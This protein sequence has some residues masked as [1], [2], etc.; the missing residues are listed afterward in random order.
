MSKFPGQKRGA[1]G[2]TV[3]ISSL[4][5]WAGAA[6]A[7]TTEPAP[8]PQAEQP[9]PADA[10]SAAPSPASSG[11]TKPGDAL[12]EVEVIQKEPPK[13]KEPEEAEVPVKKKPQPVAAKNPDVQQP[14]VK[15]AKAPAVQEAEPTL[16]APAP[17]AQVSEPSIAATLPG[18]P[19]SSTPV[20]MSPLAGSEIPLD[21][22]P[23]GVSIVSAS[24]IA[25]DGSGQLQNALAQYVPGI[26]LSDTA[27]SGFRTDVSYRGFDS[28]PVGGRSQGLAIYQN[29]VRVN[30]SF[31]DTMNWDAIPANAINDITVV[32]NNP[33]FGLNAI[34]G[35]I[36]LT[37]KDG[38]NYQGAEIDVMGGSFGRRQIAIQAGAKSG[39]FG[40]YAAGEALQEDGF[41][42]FSEAKVRRMY[43][44]LGVKSDLAE[45]HFSFTGARSEA[46]VVTAAPVELL[47]IDYGRTFTSPQITE[48]EVL[49]PT[50]S[51]SLKATETL[52]LSANAYYRS[53]KQ[54]VIDGNLSAAVPCT[55]DATILCIT[56]DAEEVVR[57][58]QGNAA[59]S[60]IGTTLGAIDRVNQEA[61]SHGVTL[62]AVEKS[63]LFGLGNQFLIG[64]SYDHGKVAYDTSSELGSIGDRF[65]VTGAGFIV[66]E[67]DDLLPR[68]LTSENDYYGLYFSNALD[69]TD[70]FTLTV[71]GRYNNATIKLT[72]LTGNFP[73]LNVTSRFERFNPMI[74]GTYKVMPGLSVYGGYSE[75]NR[76]PTAAELSCANPLNP[77]LI[78]SFLTDDPPLLQV[79]SHTAEVGLRGEQLSNGGQKLSWS[80]GYFHTLNQDDIINV[81]AT[82]TGRGYFLNAGDTL[83]QGIELAAAYHTERWSVYGSYAFIDATYQTNLV[84]PAP[85]TPG[86]PDCPGTVPADEAPCNFVSAGDHLPGIPQHRFKAGFNYW[87]T[88]QWKIGSDVITAS[89]QVFFGD[90]ANNNERLAGYTRVDLNTSYD[91]SENFQ[92]YG[93][94]KNLFDRR[95]GLYGTFFDT[96]E[97]SN[98]GVPSNVSFNDP[99]SITPAQPFAIYGGAK[100]K[101]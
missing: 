41:R 3:L 80:L 52:T 15:K 47:A 90:D 51:A 76:A 34:G 65:V 10:P 59:P 2:L 53:F 5:I 19:A 69:L 30:E 26:V 42:D 12:P 95:Y 60:S 46:G 77:C 6:S 61:K 31:G 43:A 81:A 73:G 56:E 70:A 98:A 18:P 33:V 79:V 1:A 83:R 27:G 86:A 87:L 48:Y 32:S 45:V 29:G 75:A 101:F 40:A 91:F 4:G 44:D 89:D 35:A 17:A 82:A 62:Q 55:F 63:K 24:S 22:V 50:V 38:F 25:K 64:G 39:N 7:Q 14:Q 58:A 100:L 23:S 99:Q 20:K 78:E 74:G 28:S 37:M 68:N 67:P 93:L 36:T 49:M 11:T 16:Q 94:V 71:G 88:H 84:L 54:N 8:T 92:I 9:A 13:V 96:E 85:N 97:G 72:D 66:T 57:D 21:K